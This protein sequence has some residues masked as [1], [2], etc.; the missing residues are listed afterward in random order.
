MDLFQSC[1]HCWVFQICWHKECSTFTASSFRIWNSSTGIASPPL[2][3][4]LVM[5]PRPTW[6]HIPG[7]LALDEWSHHHDYLGHKDLFCTV[8]LCILFFFNFILFY[9]LTLQYCIGFA[10]YQNES[11]TGIHVFPLL[12]PPPTSIPIPSLWVVPVHQPQASSIVHRT[13]IGDSFHIRYYT[14]FNAILPNHPTLSL[15]H[16][17]Q[18]TVLFICVSF[19]V[20]YT[21]LL[22]PSF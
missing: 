15:S 7:C 6:L 18:K 9:F 13:W 19:A 3:L 11:A 10:I 14:Y 12:N 17:V 5:F 2:A 20:S 22:L 21:G 4:F 16:R 1:G 8:L